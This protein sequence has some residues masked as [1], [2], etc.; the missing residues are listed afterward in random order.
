LYGLQLEDYWNK[1]FF[2]F[3]GDCKIAMDHNAICVGGNYTYTALSVA[4]LAMKVF[5]NGWSEVSK[6]VSIVGDLF[7]LGNNCNKDNFYG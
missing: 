5:Q 7:T 6:F 3:L 1:T 2:Y 4:K